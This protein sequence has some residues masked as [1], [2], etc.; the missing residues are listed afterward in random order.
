MHVFSV[1]KRRETVE[2]HFCSHGE[3]STP[4]VT[5]FFSIPWGTAESCPQKLGNMP[6][7]HVMKHEEKLQRTNQS[8]AARKPT[9]DKW[10]GVVVCKSSKR[11]CHNREATQI[12]NNQTKPKFG[13]E[14]TKTRAN[15]K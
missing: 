14:W 2:S 9:V 5:L 11:Y 8:K 15:I 3:E 7:Q 13:A 4:G 10:F 12:P 6:K 1:R